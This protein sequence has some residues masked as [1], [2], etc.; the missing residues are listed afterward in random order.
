MVAVM[1]FMLF[2]YHAAGIN[3]DLG[4]ILN[5][6]ILLGFLG[7]SGAT[8]T[9]AGNCGSDPDRRYGRGFQRADL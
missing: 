2:Y 4:L 3:A 8:L 9:L 1:V 5:L 7:F 6:V